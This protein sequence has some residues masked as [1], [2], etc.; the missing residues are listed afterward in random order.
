MTVL[1]SAEIGSWEDPW[2]SV[3]VI[4][5]GVRAASTRRGRDLTL[6]GGAAEVVVRCDGAGV[7]REVVHRGR[8]H[9]VVEPP[10]RWYERRN[11]WESED[12]VPRESRTSMV[13]R[14][15]WQVQA[16]QG[17]TTAP[18]TFRL[19]RNQVS[20]RWQLLGVTLG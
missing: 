17:G 16:L 2:E 12:R 9:R 7:P 8:V 15:L 1:E 6:E 14:E 5:A 3:P 10:V 4:G 20:D 19:V 13:D 11:W 18:C